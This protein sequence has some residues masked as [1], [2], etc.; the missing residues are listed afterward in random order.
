MKNWTTENDV[1]YE[2]NVYVNDL[3]FRRWFCENV[4]WMAENNF[5]WNHALWTDIFYPKTESFLTIFDIETTWDHI[6]KK[7]ACKCCSEKELMYLSMAGHVEMLEP[8]VT[9]WM[10]VQEHN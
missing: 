7:P 1:D 3:G 5:D 9:Q 10:V 4:T 8:D 6:L 2:E